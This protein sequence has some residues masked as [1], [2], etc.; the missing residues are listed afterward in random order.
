MGHHYHRAVGG[1]AIINTSQDKVW[2]SSA[3]FAS[4]SELLLIHIGK[5]FQEVQCPYAVPSLKSHQTDTPQEIRI[6]GTKAPVA[7]IKILG[8]DISVIGKESVVVT[9]HVI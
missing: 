7:V 1:Q 8:R 3:G 2:G 9:D 5:R 4:A 6:I